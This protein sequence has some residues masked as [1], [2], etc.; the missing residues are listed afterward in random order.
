[1]KSTFS[2]SIAAL[3][4]LFQI[5]AAHTWADELRVIARNGT[6]T[7]PKGYP[8]AYTP[9]IGAYQPDD[10]L[11]KLLN[12]VPDS[13]TICNP[14]QVPGA[15]PLDSSQQILSAAPGDFVAVRY[16]ENGHV[17]EPTQA[18]TPAQGKGFGSGIVYVYGTADSKATDK[19]NSIHKV[20]NKD[21]TGGDKRGKLLATQYFDDMACFL[22][23]NT[24]GNL[25]VD[26][27]TN[28]VTIAMARAEAYKFAPTSEMGVNL[29]CQTDFQIPAEA[30]ANKDYSIYWVWD[31]PTMDKK[32]GKTTV[33]EIYTS[34][35]DI[36]ITGTVNKEEVSYI[37]PQDLNN[38]A[39]WSQMVNPFVFDPTAAQKPWSMR[40][41]T[42]L[43]AKPTAFAAAGTTAHVQP[44]TAA[45]ISEQ[46]SSTTQQQAT[47]TSV[48]THQGFTTVTVYVTQTSGVTTPTGVATG[49]QAGVG[50]PSISPSVFA[51]VSTS[52]PSGVASASGSY[53][54]YPA[55]QPFMKRSLQIRGRNV[56]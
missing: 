44:T 21:G 49:A 7:A 12:T 9:R 37:A 23:G 52:V 43:F 35:A 33:S 54:P 25:F 53:A 36:A 20:W 47:A 22:A 48:S 38:A 39:Q 51:S 55:I 17:T 24:N 56:N 3:V 40:A 14:K 26:E 19:F 41:T 15:K 6:F 18:D 11:W 1:M 2:I 32:T 13:T 46:Q 29:W 34:C 50:A 42:D 28:K 27:P 10:N 30:Q 16:Q 5:T 31:W 8:R 45:S 4:L